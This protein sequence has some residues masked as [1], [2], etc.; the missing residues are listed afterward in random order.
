MR[1]VRAVNLRSIKIRYPMK[2][3]YA[4][5]LFAS[6]TLAQAQPSLTSA[7]IFPPIGASF[8][9][10]Q[11]VYEDPSPGGADLTWDFSAL[12][13]GA[14]GT[15]NYV[16]PDITEFGSQ[17]VSATV[18]SSIQGQIRYFSND[19]FSG[20]LEQGYAN[21]PADFTFP[22][23][24]PMTVVPPAVD[25]LDTW[26]D[27]YGGQTVFQGSTFERSGD[28]NGVADGWGT[29][30]MPYGSI[31]NVLRIRL[32]IHYTDVT[33][34][35]AGEFT[36]TY[37]RYYAPG[38][39][40]PLVSTLFKIENL[41]QGATSFVG[42]SLIWLSE[43]TTGVNTTANTAAFSMFP[44]PARDQVRIVAPG[45]VKVELADMQGRVVCSRTINNGTNVIDLD[46]LLAG[47]YAVST[48]DLNGDRMQH[49][50]VVE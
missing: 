12:V 25:Y 22:W 10:N 8:Q 48:I 19:G 18:A 45:T 44:N 9:V 6:A 5:L 30:I 26:N 7:G 15:M 21:E 34:G 14:T 33:I 40:E 3:C 35:A 46:G 24:S 41:G 31:D 1:L 28:M 16:D 17:F 20:L 27:T 36:E 32:I 2:Q 42:S 4:V 11:G 38:I 47:T 49:L 37:Y 13:S 39:S 43:V 29:V 23:V 50:L